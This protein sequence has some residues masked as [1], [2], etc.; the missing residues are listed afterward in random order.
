MRFSYEIWDDPL[1]FCPLLFGWV[2]VLKQW[3]R[4]AN[5]VVSSQR[6]NLHGPLLVLFLGGTVF[7]FC[8]RAIVC[9]WYWIRH[10]RDLF[11]IGPTVVISDWS[12]L[13][14]APY[15]SWNTAETHLSCS[16]LLSF[17]SFSHDLF[18]LFERL[19]L[20]RRL[21]LPTI[22]WDICD[23][24]QTTLVLQS[25][26]RQM[27]STNEQQTG[28]FTEMLSFEVLTAVHSLSLKIMYLL[29]MAV[30]SVHAHSELVWF[31]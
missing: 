28:F 26:L 4:E 7:Y 6:E 22:C 17:S 1:P 12:L 9:S 19:F 25:R 23:I 21:I 31:I 14:F 5:C 2:V 27:Y 16:M 24:P 30:L 8:S 20:N 13:S 15:L 3:A 18:S 29:N 10:C 11:L